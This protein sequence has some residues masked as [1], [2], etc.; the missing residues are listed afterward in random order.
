MAKAKVVRIAR[1]G[2]PEVLEIAEAEVTAPGPGEV[3]LR[4]TAVGLNYIDINHRKGT[5]ALPSLPMVIGMEGAGIVE[6]AG[7]GV[8]TVR[9]G[10]RV[11]YCMVLGAYADRRLIKADRL[12]KLPD[13]VSEEIGAAATLQGLTAQY[14]VRDSYPIKRG[15]TVLVHAAAG[16]VGLILCQWAKHLGAT[17][18][19]TVSTE[20]KAKLAAAH[21][22]DH[23]ILYTREDFAARVKEI[24]KGA[25]V[26][27]VYD[28]VGKDT[29]EGSWTCLGDFGR[30][31][32]YGE[33]S[34]PVPPLDTR[35][36]GAKALSFAR[37]AL[38]PFTA[39]AAR[40]DPR[41]AE[42]FS[43]IG[44]GALKIEI[45]QRYKLAEAA[46]AQSDMEGRRTTGSSILIP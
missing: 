18:L 25:G 16:G 27:A 40:R 19:G 15:D 44:S 26:N 35:K 9:E 42:L 30:M 8:T 43:M 4:Q 22:C 6:A 11:A 17:V 45:N 38:G 20:A 29:W 2:G 13:G 14:L 28:A 33:S 36:M 23:P 1:T 32:S 46:E 3:V 10:D 5:Y 34:G 7:P 41:A 21:G 39:T 12:I 31:V 24:T 37:G